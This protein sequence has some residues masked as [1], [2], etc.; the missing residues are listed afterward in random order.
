MITV[1][2]KEVLRRQV[3]V[4]GMSVREVARL[5]HR[6]RETV[7]QALVDAPRAVYRLKDAR[8]CPV[9]DPFREI[10]DEWLLAD[11]NEP[12]KQRHTAH[13]I[14]TRLCAAPHHFRGGEPTVRR[15]VRERKAALGLDQPA[16]FIP[17]AYG[18]GQDAQFD[19]GEA[20]VSIA[21]QRVTAQYMVLTL[22]TGPGRL[23]AA[24]RD[25]LSPSAAGSLVRR[26]RRGVRIPGR[27]AAADLV[28]QSDAGRA[29]HPRRA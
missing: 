2:Q 22:C 9:M 1:E 12:P 29:A 23:D 11:Q 21:G 13:R 24:V 14:Y 3:L 17:L 7:K 5:N 10:I 25:G 19:F 8:R 20:Q 27:C 15:F 4:D 6:S 26:P 28:R 18:P 16:A